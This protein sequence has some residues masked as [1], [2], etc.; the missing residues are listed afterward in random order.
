MSYGVSRYN[1]TYAGTEEY[2]IAVGNPL[3]VLGAISKD[4]FAV[5]A[6]A[7]AFMACHPLLPKWLAH[8]LKIP[9]DSKLHLVKLEPIRKIH[10]GGGQMVPNIFYTYK[11]SQDLGEITEKMLQ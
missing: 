8:E 2:G 4:K 1:F 6:Q 7:F 10:I 5:L 9:I 3:C 11:V